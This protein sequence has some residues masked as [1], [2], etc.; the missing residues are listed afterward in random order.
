VR[1]PVSSKMRRRVE[2]CTGRSPTP[3]RSLLISTLHNQ[4]E[5]KGLARATEATTVV[6]LFV[7]DELKPAIPENPEQFAE[8]SWVTTLF[9]REISTCNFIV[10]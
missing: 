10:L 9:I 2:F 7:S 3:T 8:M 4:R 5:G 6:D 1:E